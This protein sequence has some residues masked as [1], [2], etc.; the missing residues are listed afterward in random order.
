MRQGAAPADSS[1]LAF[2]PSHPPSFINSLAAIPLQSTAP[3]ATIP[4]C[5][6]NSNVA[7]PLH[8]QSYEARQ[9]PISDDE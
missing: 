9:A 3:A 7:H 6:E 1:H 2:N 8:G 4:Q 5:R